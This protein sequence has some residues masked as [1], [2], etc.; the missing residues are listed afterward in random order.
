[1]TAGSTVSAKLTKDR[2]E[3][4]F[5]GIG[6]GRGDGSSDRTLEAFDAW[7]DGRRN[8]FPRF[9]PS[10]TWLLIR[11]CVSEFA[12]PIFVDTMKSIS[13]VEQVVMV[14]IHRLGLPVCEG[15][16]GSIW[17]RHGVKNDKGHYGHAAAPKFATST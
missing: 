15:L 14:R 13:A 6:Q 4:T 12:F 1:M 7:E 10:I 2:S 16:T 11:S 9:L 17:G 3:P 8:F 5:L